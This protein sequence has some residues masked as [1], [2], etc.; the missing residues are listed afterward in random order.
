TQSTISSAI[1]EMETLLGA[2]LI[3]RSNRKKLVFTALGHAML[4]SGE[5]VIAQLSR[6]A[7]RARRSDNLLSTPLRIGVIPTIAPYV[8]PRILRPLQQAFPSLALHLHEMQTGALI[9]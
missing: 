4:Q 3:D 5:Q 8:L 1:R 9:D 7:E 6:L 2:T